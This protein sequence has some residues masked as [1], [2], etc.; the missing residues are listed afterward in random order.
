MNIRKKLL[1]VIGQLLNSDTDDRYHVRRLVV[2]SKTREVINNQ[3][4]K[5]Q[6]LLIS[7][8]SRGVKLKTCTNIAL[9]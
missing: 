5:N 4:E 8:L 1:D 7:I 2:T 3:F 6:L 9:C